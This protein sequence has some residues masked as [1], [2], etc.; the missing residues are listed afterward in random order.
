MVVD[1]IF[2]VVF[3]SFSEKREQ[4]QMNDKKKTAKKEKPLTKI[5]NSLE[6]CK[7]CWPP[8][9]EESVLELTSGSRPSYGKEG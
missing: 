1:I 3:S 2:M 9:V 7:K 6:F 8:C 4:Q 5:C